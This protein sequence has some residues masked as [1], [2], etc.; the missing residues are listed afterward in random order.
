MYYAKY[1]HLQD[2]DTALISAAAA[3][4]DECVRLLLQGGAKG[5]KDQVCRLTCHLRMPVF[6]NLHG[7]EHHRLRFTFVSARLNSH[8]IGSL[9]SCADLG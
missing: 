5:V 2:G 9:I 8:V 4:R 1:L 6:A 7:S 3:G